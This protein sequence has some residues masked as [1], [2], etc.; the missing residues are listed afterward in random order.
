MQPNMN[1]RR[2]LELSAGTG[3]ALA[4]GGCQSITGSSRHKTSV[5]SYLKDYADLYKDD[6]R[7]AAR[8]WFAEAGFGLFMHYGLYSQLGRGEWVMLRERIPVA[9]YVKL[10]DQFTA[11]DF[12][13]DFITDLA[14][15]AGMKYVNLTSRHHDGFCL[16]E[17]RQHDYHSVAA[18]A[19]RDIIG[20]LANAC[21][22]KG[23]GLFLYYSYA[24]DWWHPYFYPRE[25]GWAN[26]RPAYDQP[27]PEYKWRKDEDFGIYVNYVHAQLRELLSK[28]GPIAG[29]WFDPIMGFYNRPDLFPIDET[30][31]LVRSLQP[32]TL[33]SFKQGAS[34]TE[35][36]AAPERSGH[37]LADR[38]KDPAHREV[39]RKAWEGNKDKHNE[40]CD[41]LQPS[42]WGYKK[43][44]DSKHLDADEVLKRLES[45]W[46]A[47]C[48][49]LMNTGP[50]PDGS[51][52]TDDV[53]TL[54]QVGQRLR[55][56]S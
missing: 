20:N 37:S 39:A 8:Q 55:R 54:R 43:A 47:N 28:Y 35:D 9:E 36:F 12:G 4:I 50:L 14:L 17:T 16:F 56:T 1:R 44:D 31:A 13:V 21:H 33:I 3:A 15:E 11:Q 7:Q 19:H 22:Q 45:A 30:Y 6:P 18:P 38:L 24:A 32:H 34:G 41:T 49:L 27:Q 48:N 40:I 42:V 23:L 51:I 10:K 2:F 29:I 26:A 52:H 25:A 5:P 46:A 53:K